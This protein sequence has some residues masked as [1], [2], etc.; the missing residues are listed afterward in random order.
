MSCEMSRFCA[1]CGRSLAHVEEPPPVPLEEAGLTQRERAFLEGVRRYGPLPSREL[2]RA[3][4][5]THGGSAINVLLRRGLVAREPASDGG[6][7]PR[8][9]AVPPPSVGGDARGGA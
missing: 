7:Y 6:R 3:L 2:A 9:Y 8:Y 5:H 1:H 4:G